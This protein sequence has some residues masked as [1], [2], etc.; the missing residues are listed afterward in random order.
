MNVYFDTKHPAG[1]SGAAALRRATGLPKNQVDN[2]LRS[3]EAYTLHAPARKRFQRNY[4]KVSSIDDTWQ[5]DLCDMRHLAKQNDGCNYMLTVIDLLSKYA[6]AQPLK[7]KSAESVKKAF[8]IITRE[9]QPRHLMTDKGK[10]F[11]NGTMK[12]FLRIETSTFTPPR[13]LISKPVSQKGLT[14]R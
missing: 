5:A 11:V 6:W 3:H 7:S 14:V 2:F 9:R 1:Y 13:T 8:E 4:Y 10:G 12:K